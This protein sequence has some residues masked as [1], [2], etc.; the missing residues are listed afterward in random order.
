MTQSSIDWPSSP[1]GI[2]SAHRFHDAQ[3][4]QLIGEISES[5]STSWF[6]MI[7]PREEPPR[8]EGLPEIVQ[9]DILKEHQENL[10]A[11]PEEPTDSYRKTALEYLKSMRDAR[12]SVRPE[13]L[14][15]LSDLPTGI[16]RRTTED[17]IFYEVTEEIGTRRDDIEASDAEVT[18]GGKYLFFTPNNYES[19]ENIVLD[20]FRTRPFESAKVSTTVNQW[21]EVVLCLYYSDDRYKRD[22]RESYQN[23]EDPLEMA[24]PYDADEPIIKPRGFKIGR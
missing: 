15:P 23:E 14:T 3:L 13:S 9:E 12:N 11:T 20:Q 7:T 18:E 5:N 17:W 2:R 22:L 10:D 6:S 8:V 24:S 1:D 21:E 19:L 16:T 4:N